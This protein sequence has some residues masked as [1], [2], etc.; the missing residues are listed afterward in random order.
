[1]NNIFL[2][3]NEFYSRNLSE[4]EWQ[5]NFS[6]HMVLDSDVEKLNAILSNL[7]SKK[8]EYCHFINNVTVTHCNVMNNKSGKYIKP[9]LVD[10]LELSC[11]ET[12]PKEQRRLEIFSQI[13]DT[14]TF[15]EF[16]EK[17][18]IDLLTAN[19]SEYISYKSL[20]NPLP[21]F[22]LPH[23]LT[24]GSEFRLLRDVSCNLDSNFNYVPTT[25]VLTFEHIKKILMNNTLTLGVREFF[26]I[27]PT[28]T[29]TAICLHNNILIIRWSTFKSIMTQ[30]GEQVAQDYLEKILDR[31]LIHLSSEHRYNMIDL[32][33][34]LQDRCEKAVYNSMSVKIKDGKI[35]EDDT[36]YKSLQQNICNIVKTQVDKL[37]NE[38]QNILYFKNGLYNTMLNEMFDRVMSQ[39]KQS[40]TKYFLDGV[41]LSKVFETKGW[42]YLESPT[43]DFSA[44][45]RFPN[46]IWWK[47]DLNLY[48]DKFCRDGQLYELS[49]DKKNLYKI[50]S[51]YI[52][53]VGTVLVKQ[54]YDSSK[55][56]YHHPNVSGDYLVCLG[57]LKV[58][59]NPSKLSLQEFSEFLDSVVVLLQTI[60]FDSPYARSDYDFL[61][62][63]SKRIECSSFRDNEF[64]D[65]KK[66][67]A[68][69]YKRVRP[70]NEGLSH[71]DS[72]SVASNNLR[73]TSPAPID[74]ELNRVASIDHRDI[75]RVSNILL[76]VERTR[77]PVIDISV[78]W[79]RTHTWLHPNG[80]SYFHFYI[81]DCYTHY[82]LY[83]KNRYSSLYHL[84]SNEFNDCIKVCKLVNIST[85]SSNSSSLRD[86]LTKENIDK[87]FSPILN[88]I[89]SSSISIKDILFKLINS[90]DSKLDLEKLSE[91]LPNP[92]LLNFATLFNNLDNKNEVVLSNA[93]FALLKD[94]DK[95]NN[96]DSVVVEE[97]EE[98]AEEVPK[99]PK[100]RSDFSDSSQVSSTGPTNATISSIDSVTT[101]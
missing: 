77:D 23:E 86:Y 94:S 13:F 62:R 65:P 50:V 73:T 70:L 53:S 58:K 61:C 49:D 54:E 100:R 90:R 81:Y 1:M 40:R 26:Y 98:L 8:P 12:F 48:V 46:D 83:Q 88:K 67:E 30:F 89:K 99:I 5:F 2:V 17:D 47:K 57:D 6:K 84:D 95:V 20:L 4:S 9:V 55:L 44:L 59:A 64:G 101:T 56:K 63:D 31:F 28:S 66:K 32:N 39:V 60:N 3:K 29:L 15:T 43:S 74:N 21:S 22:G 37:L 82:F 25:S 19:S 45:Q 91:Q 34:Y 92:L 76:S 79:N 33:Q 16:G 7:S 14:V 42:V 75:E 27:G 52:S 24:S 18:L 41:K 72:F 10:L 69:T 93:Q 78:I 96:A 85:L 35:I 38:D 71:P 68:S 80:Q 36:Y 97:E 87:F 11:N 51:M